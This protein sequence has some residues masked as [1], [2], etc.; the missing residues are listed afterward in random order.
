MY[1]SIVM[2]IRKNDEGVEIFKINAEMCIM[3][4]GGAD[5]KIKNNDLSKISKKNI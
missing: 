1:E 3:K 5:H 4:R 2:S